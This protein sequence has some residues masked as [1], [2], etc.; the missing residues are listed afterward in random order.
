MTKAIDAVKARLREYYT[1][2]VEAVIREIGGGWVEDEYRRM[3]R[4]CAYDVIEE[5]HGIDRVDAIMA[6]VD[7][8]WGVDA[9]RLLAAR[10]AV[11]AEYA[12]A[13]LDADVE[14]AGFDTMTADQ[15]MDEITYLG[16]YQG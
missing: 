9:D 5:R 2:N 10:A 4:A 3:V 15:L 1:E 13:G 14:I 8:S 6:E 16:D 12:T 7:P 11:R